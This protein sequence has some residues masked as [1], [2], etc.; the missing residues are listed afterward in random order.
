M[1][2]PCLMVADIGGTNARFALANAENPG[3]SHERTYQCVD[4]ASADQAIHA[5]L[6]E[7][8]ANKPIAI[9]I[10]AAGPIVDGVVRF[11]NNSWRI[12]TADLRETRY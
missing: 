2:V 6:K 3:F 1:A 5:Y 12:E 11:T 9:C 10:A 7:V 4:F 8:N